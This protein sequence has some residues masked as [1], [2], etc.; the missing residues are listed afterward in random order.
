MADGVCGRKRRPCGWQVG[1]SREH[2]HEA[3]RRARDGGCGCGG[4]DARAD[5]GPASGTASWPYPDRTRVSRRRRPSPA[6][7]RRSAAIRARHGDESS[8]TTRGTGLDDQASPP[9]RRA[10][11]A[12]PPRSELGHQAFESF[13]LAG[14]VTAVERRDER[15]RATLA[16]VRWAGIRRGRSR[17]RP[18]GARDEVPAGDDDEHRGGDNQRPAERIGSTE[19]EIGGAA[20]AATFAVSSGISSGVS[21]ERTTRVRP[22]HIEGQGLAVAARRLHL[23]RAEARSA[24]CGSGHRAL[25][26]PWR[27]CTQRRRTED[28]TRT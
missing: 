17:R 10:R 22:A 26:A 2:G 18:D 27:G 8:A 25:R 5:R 24:R 9:R 3:L 16:G 28:G 7:W 23:C 11:S 4:R 6:A 20:K 19:Y 21:R 15:E 13:S 12:C 14:C 1:R